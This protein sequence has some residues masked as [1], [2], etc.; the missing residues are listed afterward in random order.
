MF[1][2]KK[3]KSYCIAVKGT[4]GLLSRAGHTTIFSTCD[5]VRQRIKAYV[6]D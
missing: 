1:G 2:N 4:G 6:T 3:I 5:N